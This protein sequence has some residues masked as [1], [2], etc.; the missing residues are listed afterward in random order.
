[1]IINLIYVWQV[2]PKENS[3]WS[4]DPKEGFSVQVSTEH[5]GLYDCFASLEDVDEPVKMEFYLTVQRKNQISSPIHQKKKIGKKSVG[6]W[7]GS[8]VVYLNWR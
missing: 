5:S 6:T 7:L 3:D 4:Y 2:Y 1:M 8:A